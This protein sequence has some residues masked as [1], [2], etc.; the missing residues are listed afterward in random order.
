MSTL[1]SVV[2]TS[3][4]NASVSNTGATASGSVLSLTALNPSTL[5]YTPTSTPPAV[6]F[7]G[8]SA[9]LSG[10]AAT[11]DT[12]DLTAL[13]DNEG[14]AVDGTGAKVQ[15]FII[16]AGS[17]N[18]AT[19]TV[20]D[21]DTNAYSLFGS[22]NEVNLQAGMSVRMRCNDQLSDIAAGVKN[23]KIAGTGGDTYTYVF[24]IG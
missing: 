13:T 12:L 7:P 2:S 11:S 22:G 16:S 1:Q 8:G 23:I 15:E 17:S 3:T 14:I 4:L 18:A 21:G 9:T 10:S 24:V 5:T 20:S 6:Y 19:L